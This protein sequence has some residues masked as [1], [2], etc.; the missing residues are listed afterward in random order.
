LITVYPKAEI[1]FPSPLIVKLGELRESKWQKLVKRVAGLPEVH[2]ERLAFVL[3]MIRLDGC[4]KCYNGSF[5][6]M[7]GCALCARQTVM[8]FKESDTQLLRIYRQA[9]K[10]VTKH[11]AKHG[12][13]GLAD[14]PNLQELLAEN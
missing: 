13:V 10:D 9:L 2:P 12:Y 8:Q 6:F 14:P 4:L 1:M 3:L 11:L 5:R 7:R